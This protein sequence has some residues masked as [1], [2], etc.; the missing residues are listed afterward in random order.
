MNQTKVL[1]LVM[2]LCW[3]SHQDIVEIGYN[4]HPGRDYGEYSNRIK[5]D[6][7]LVDIPDDYY[8]CGLAFL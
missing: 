3:T 4:F 1:I 8:V 6:P 5:A 2:V 7:Q